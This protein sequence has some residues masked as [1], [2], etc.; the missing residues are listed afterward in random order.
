MS[1]LK[2]KL[3]QFFDRSA[4][5]LRIPSIGLEISFLPPVPR[6]KKDKADLPTVLWDLPGGGF[7]DIVKE[8]KPGDAPAATL[9]SPVATSFVLAVRSGAPDA[10]LK[11]MG[12]TA[13]RE[14]GPIR[15]E[16]IRDELS[17][18]IKTHLQNC[19]SDECEIVHT[20][21]RAVTHLTGVLES[22]ATA[23]N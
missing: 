18:A 16:A 19:P 9:L 17:T 6:E 11:E 8:A 15:V 12:N 7:Q 21:R 4:F 22:N 2:K 3:L 13:L 20:L 23:I 1:Y 14:I 5:L 10:S